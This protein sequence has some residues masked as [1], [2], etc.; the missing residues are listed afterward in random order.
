MRLKKLFKVKSTVWDVLRSPRTVA[1]LKL[2]AAIIGVIH[3]IDELSGL[4]KTGK[5]PVGF[6]P[7]VDDSNEES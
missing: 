7:D 4:P 3:A 2:G 1:Y 5:N 6:H